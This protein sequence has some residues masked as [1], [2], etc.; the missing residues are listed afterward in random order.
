MNTQ[1]LK[2]I[3]LILLSISIIFVIIV[4][5]INNNNRKK[6]SSIKVE[7]RNKNDVWYNA[8]L[9]IVKVPFM[10]KYIERIR[11]QIEMVDLSDG[12]TICKKAMKFTAVSLGG[13]SL[14]FLIMFYIDRTPYFLIMTFITI[15]ILHNQI[16]KYMLENIEQKLLFQLEKFLADVR[17]HYHEHGM[18]DEAIYD[19]IETSPYEISLHANRIYEVLTSDD[20]ESEMDKY[21]DNA[22]NKYFR[23]FV[24]LCYLVQ[25]FGD[26]VVE[27]KST[28][29]LNLNYLK[30]EINIEMLKRQ[31]LG[32]L[33]KS[34]SVITIAPMFFIKPI[35]SWAINNL[36][37]LSEYYKGSYGFIV[38]I[39]LF[40][41]IILVYQL[42]NK[43]STNQ[44]KLESL[45]ATKLEQKLYEINYFRRLIII[46]KNKNY[47]RALKLNNILR[48]TGAR[49]TIELFYLKRLVYL[50]IGFAIM[51]SVFINAHII[52]K[53]NILYTSYGV[54]SVYEQDKAEKTIKLDRAIIK[55]YKNKQV[56]EDIIKYELKNI[57][58]I[59]DNQ[60]LE[61]S[62]NRIMKKVRVYNSN[63]FKWW[64]LIVCIIMAVLFYNIPYWILLFRKKMMQMNMEDEV[65]QFHTVI[66]ML[67]YIEEITVEDILNWMEQFAVVFKTSIRKCLNDFEYG[68]L[69]ALEQL[70]VD[71]PFIPFV[72]VIENLQSASDK[73]SI[74]QAFDELLIE[75]DYYKEKRKQE[76]EIVVN[77]KGMWGKFIA[78]APLTLTI[79]LYILVPF[80][81]V[82]IQQLINY[83]EQMKS[84]L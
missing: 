23:T 82:S 32:Y 74:V 71:E 30:Q 70:K 68:D 10:K 35:E 19:A 84:V 44:A 66:I 80:V 52:N 42:I 29:L 83:K 59:K 61:H 4:L 78:F 48:T 77:Q 17:H 38:Q 73:I 72:R 81:L 33:F 54:N 14:L 40:L 62:T 1:T 24:A 41:T 5:I 47:S 11:R 75:R 18:V 63:Y 13:S 53:H 3:I 76:N 46:I 22:P 26:K 57:G 15:Y 67:M 39:I 55:K 25:K 45:V 79:C 21:N 2:Q 31:K 65:L 58:E 56:T 50:V 6:N 9:T 49:I 43:M 27:N 36:S 12:Y 64:E 37:E 51:L 20:V 60:L 16:I 7:K 69:E 8:Y 34:L 28:F